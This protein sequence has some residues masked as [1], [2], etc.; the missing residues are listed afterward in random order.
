MPD[1]LIGGKNPVIETLKSDRSVHKIW[2]ADGMKPSALQS[3]VSLAKKKNVLIQRVP[4]RKLDDMKIE[5]HQGVVAQIAAY[6]YSTLDDL[7]L[8]AEQRNEMPFFLILD[9]IE[10]PHN[11]GSILRTA[12]CV[13]VH[14]IIIPKHRAVGLTHTVA[15]ASTGAIEH[16]PVVRVTNIAQTLKVLKDAGLWI[17]AADLQNSRDYREL[18]AN[19]PLALVIGSEGKGISRIVSKSCDFIY[20]LPMVGQVTSLNASVAAALFLYEIYRKRYPF[21]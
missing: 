10:D 11:L 5:N 3:I 19:F 16:V 7:F 1:I 9:E 20:R 17:I 21:A 12:D 4:K 13:G 18:E 8:Q 14:G 6:K 15:K 2:V